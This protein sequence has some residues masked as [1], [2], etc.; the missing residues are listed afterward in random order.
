M[1]Q[2][3]YKFI[4]KYKDPCIPG[5]NSTKTCKAFL[6]CRGGVCK[7]AHIGAACKVDTDCY[8][9]NPL[10]GGTRCVQEKCIKPRYFVFFKSKDITV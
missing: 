10:Y 2:R 3:M 4:F 5:F 7:K 8:A 9:F 6:A 1:E